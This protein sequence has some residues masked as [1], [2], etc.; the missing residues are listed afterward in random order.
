MNS[1]LSYI[2]IT[3]LSSLI[4]TNCKKTSSP[5]ASDYNPVTAG[6]SWTYISGS[7]VFKLTATNRDTVAA[8][9]NYKVLTNSNGP[10]N[11]VAKNGNDYFR[12]GAI[13]AI[14]ANGIE[15]LY[16]K[17]NEDIN[18]TW[19]GS[20]SFTAPGFG[21]VTANLKYTIKAKGANRT[22][23]GKNFNNVTEVRLDISISGFSIGGGDFYYAEGVGMIEN[24]INVA[25]PGQTAIAQTQVLTSYEIK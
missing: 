14:G 1:K 18:G 25:I 8:G 4:F 3:I 10:N 16:L 24:N 22:V 2:L 12:F 20:Q 6:S 17:G 15:E 13:A 11:Y 5:V 23:S 21:A 19:S 7:S 9:R